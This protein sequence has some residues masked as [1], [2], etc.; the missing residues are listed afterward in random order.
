M[1]YHLIKPKKNVLIFMMQFLLCNKIIKIINYF[2]TKNQK[3]KKFKI[4][5]KNFMEKIKKFRWMFLIFNTNKIKII[6]EILKKNYISQFKQQKYLTYRNSL[7]N[8]KEY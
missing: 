8:L 2:N 5:L 1:K 4:I 6:N 7:K 3:P